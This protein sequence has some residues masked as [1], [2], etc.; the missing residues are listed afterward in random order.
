MGAGL[1]LY[2]F[3]DSRK[4]AWGAL[5]VKLRK[6]VEIADVR[7]VEIESAPAKGGR[8]LRVAVA[9]GAA[10][11]GAEAMMMTLQL[12][13]EDTATA[14]AWQ[15]CLQA[16]VTATTEAMAQGVLARHLPPGDDVDSLAT[17]SLATY[18]TQEEDAWAHTHT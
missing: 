5:P 9:V 15:R 4:G 11:V 17:G 18:D 6:V 13:A 7:E 3:Q 1:R 14:M 10:V 16:A 12:R 8:C 2:M